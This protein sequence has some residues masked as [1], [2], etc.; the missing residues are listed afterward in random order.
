MLTM[1]GFER[2]GKL[3]SPHT[4]QILNISGVDLVHLGWVNREHRGCQSDWHDV[5][6]T[7]GC[8]VPSVPCFPLGLVTGI[9]LLWAGKVGMSW[10]FP[11]GD[12]PD[13]QS[14]MISSRIREN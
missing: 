10:W 2:S 4:E 12:N 11:R 3:T 8:A 14:A 13:Q 1:F 5:G 7:K 6:K 9:S